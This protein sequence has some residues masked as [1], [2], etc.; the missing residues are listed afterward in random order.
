MMMS[1]FFDRTN[2]TPSNEEYGFIEESYYDFDG[3]KNE[4]CKQWLKDKK[5]GHWDKEL[6][7]RKKMEEQKKDFLRK[8]DEQ[9]EFLAFYR[10]E[11][12][13]KLELEKQLKEA[14]EKLERLERV[15]RRTFDETKTA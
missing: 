2:Y 6:E 11:Y 14:Q 10:R 1:E 12:D 8:I 7:L 15:F 9:N 4:F 13:R 3:D 5:D